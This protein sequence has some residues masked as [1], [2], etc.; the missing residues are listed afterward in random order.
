MAISIKTTGGAQRVQP[1]A[2][3]GSVGSQYYSATFGPAYFVLEGITTEPKYAIQIWNSTLTEQIAD[4]RQAA[5]PNGEAAFNIQNILQSYV[6]P[7]RGNTSTLNGKYNIEWTGYYGNPFQTSH[8]EVYDYKIKFGYEDANGA[9]VQVGSTQGPYTT[10]GGQYNTSF[11]NAIEEQPNRAYIGPQVECD[12][13]GCIQPDI[14]NTAASAINQAYT[15]TDNEDLRLPNQLT[16]GIPAEFLNPSVKRIACSKTTMSQYATISFLN[17]VNPA[18]SSEV[19]EVQPTQIV[20]VRLQSYDGTTPVDDVFYYNT[21]LEGGGPDTFTGEGLTVEGEFTAIYFGA[22]GR[23]LVN[24][25]SANVTHYYLS[26]HTIQN[27]GCESIPGIPNAALKPLEVWRYD[28]DTA[29]CND[30]VPINVSWLNSRGYRDYFTFNK[31]N[32]TSTNVKRQT[33]Y[34]GTEPVTGT[35]Y[36]D[37]GRN[38]RGTTTFNSTVSDTMTLTTDWLTDSEAATLRSLFISPDVKIQIGNGIDLYAVQLSDA[39][40][41]LKNNRKD[42]LFQYTITITIAKNLNQNRG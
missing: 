21:T 17:K 11:L 3:T 35:T 42:R 2:T 14:N 30:Y 27:S 41:I 20:G 39:T 33:Y 9:F 26:T 8:N 10:I 12:L 36:N 31:K 19:C 16:G 24:D 28:I 18:A 6:A 40:Y 22:G 15:L 1:Y 7:G 29:T 32:E 23:N 5:D 13:A 38:S 37:W 4:L 25:L 34:T